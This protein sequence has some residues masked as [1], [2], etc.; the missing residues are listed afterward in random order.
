MAVE[1]EVRG[2]HQY[3]VK[4]GRNNMSCMEARD[5]WKV[6]GQCRS[7][8][9]AHRPRTTTT[10]IKDCE[11]TVDSKK[12]KADEADHDEG[13]EELEN[14]ETEASEVGREDGD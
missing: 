10:N 5:M 8:P 14:A 3:F 13:P 7:D 9:V 1:K 12:T 6:M 11:N 4:F 2:G